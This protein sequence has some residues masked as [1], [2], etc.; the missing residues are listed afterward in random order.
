MSAEVKKIQNIV[1]T[2]NKTYTGGWLGNACK[3]KCGWACDPIDET[4]K[5]RKC[6]KCGTVFERKSYGWCQITERL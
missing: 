2:S 5:A 6:E 4:D 3:C 1:Q